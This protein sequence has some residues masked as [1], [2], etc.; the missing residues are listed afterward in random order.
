MWSL[1]SYAF[2]LKIVLY[3]EDDIYV[4][5]CVYR[6]ILKTVHLMKSTNKCNRFDTN[7]SITIFSIY[8]VL[9]LRPALRL[10]FSTIFHGVQIN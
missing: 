5:M 10:A 6:F 8:S 4:D 1:R 3:W 7:G 9:N 2:K